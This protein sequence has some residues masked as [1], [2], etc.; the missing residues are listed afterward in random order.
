MKKR[1]FTLIELM[2]TL[3]LLATIA[4][5]TIPIVDTQIKKGKQQLYDNAIESIKLS[6]EDWLSDQHI[7]LKE[8][9]S[10]SITLTQ[11]KQSKK[12]DMNI[13]NPIN[14]EF[15]PSDM[16]LVASKTSSGLV[17]EV[18]DDTGS[19]KDN[20]FDLPTI[21]LNGNV[22]TYVELDASKTTNYTDLGAIAKDSS[23]NEIS[24]STS[25]EPT[26]D[27]SKP[28][29]YFVTYSATSNGKTNKI[30]RTII[31]R[32]TQGPTIVFAND[33]S[34]SLSEVYNYDFLN[35]VTVTDNSGETIQATVE[36]NFSAQ[37][38]TYTITYKA[39]DSAGNI[40]TK[41]RK[42]TVTE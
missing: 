20:Y 13:T 2:G 34:I 3:I 1:G 12:T 28:G 29:S 6:F 9:E 36:T 33:L 21:T 8:N 39:K 4:L 31:V 11:L 5:I 26:L 41:L 19:S 32:D 7:T 27:I 17:Y 22:I 40:T 38:G 42:V 10:V 30:I 23:D 37:T 24:V 14:E 25:T 16:V 15:L 35:D 18:K